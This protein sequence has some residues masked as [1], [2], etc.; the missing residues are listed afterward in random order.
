MTENI[1]LRPWKISDLNNLIQYA[2]NPQI[3]ENLTNAFPHPYT[4]EA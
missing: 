4:K 2:N 3:A 1:S